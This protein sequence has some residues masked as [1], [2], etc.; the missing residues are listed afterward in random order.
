MSGSI[1]V[2][3]AVDRPAD[4]S[5]LAVC[6]L[7]APMHGIRLWLVDLGGQL[8]TASDSW[9][10]AGELDRAARFVFARDAR[11]YRAAHVALRRLLLQHCGLRAAAEFEIGDHG[12]PRAGLSPQFEFNLSHSGEKALIGIDQGQG[13]GIGVDI[14]SMRCIE[15]V[16]PLAEQHFSEGEYRELHA[17][18]QVDVARAFLLG[19][20]RKEACL[21]ALGCGLSVAP[22]SV[23]VGLKPDA[24]EVVVATPAGPAPVWV[25]SVKV[26]VD[27]LAAVAR[28]SR[29][30]P[31]RIST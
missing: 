9:L 8:C 26:G 4:V 20:T 14:E 25:S 21:K 18:P 23:E 6:G 1:V 24:R 16:W 31:T 12:K 30:S 13:D 19:W 11:R 28:V 27:M 17:V 5:E 22:A 3:E 2:L 15:D 29:S 10:S 7:P